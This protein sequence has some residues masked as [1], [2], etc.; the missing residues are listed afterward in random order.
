MNI[1]IKKSIELET[2]VVACTMSIR[3]LR[4]FFSERKMIVGR[5]KVQAIRW[6]HQNFLV[7]LFYAMLLKMYVFRIVVMKDSG[8]QIDQL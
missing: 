8:F 5:G 3:R 6:M 1:Q 4:E 2:L 7:E